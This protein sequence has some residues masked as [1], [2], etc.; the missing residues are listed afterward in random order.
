MA[1]A[2]SKKAIQSIP[3]DQISSP[4]VQP[5]TGNDPAISKIYKVD[6]IHLNI[7]QNRRK[8]Q[9]TNRRQKYDPKQHEPQLNNLGNQMNS[10]MKQMKVHQ[11]NERKIARQVKNLT[12][13]LKGL[14]L[15]KRPHTTTSSVDSKLGFR[16]YRCNKPGHQMLNC[17]TILPLRRCRE[18]HYTQFRKCRGNF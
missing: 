1:L 18:F 13:I 12:E 4:E 16:C 11:D 8:T 9:P 3:A 5:V 6:Q 17:P 14:N 15:K 7:N 2:A 10:L